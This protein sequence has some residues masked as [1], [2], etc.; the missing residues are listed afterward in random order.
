MIKRLIGSLFPVWRMWCLFYYEAALSQI[1]PMH[2]DVPALVLRINE[3][4]R[5]A[6]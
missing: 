5:S 3:L 2:E 1:D 4:R 6:A